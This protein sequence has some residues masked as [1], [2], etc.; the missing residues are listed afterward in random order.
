MCHNSKLYVS[1]DSPHRGANIPIGVQYM[2]DR[3]SGVFV[4]GGQFDANRDKLLR[5]AAKQMLVYHF[6]PDATQ[7]R[8]RWQ[9]WQ[10]SAGSYPTLLRKVALSNGNRQG[11][12]LP[13]A[14]TGMELL[15]SSRVTPWWG[16]NYANSLPGASSRGHDNVVFRYQKAITL[17]G[18]W[19]YTQ[20]AANTPTYD[21][22]PG[23]TRTTTADAEKEGHGFLRSGSDYQTF[24]PA[25]SALDV[26][27]AGSIYNPNLYYDINNNI[28]PNWPNP[29]KYAFEAYY[30]PAGI[31]EPHI[32]ITNGQAYSPHGNPTYTSNNTAWILNELAESAHNLPALLTG[33]YNFGSLYRRLL[34]S[35][36]VGAGG[37]IFLNNANLPN[38]GGVSTANDPKR[39]S[40][41]MYT[42]GCGSRVQ[43]SQG[44]TLT[45]GQ[46]NDPYL[47]TARIGNLSLLDLR[48]GSQ[49]VVNA[50]SVLRIAKGG[51][52]VLRG[53]ASLTL[54]GQL[55]VEAGAY[56][57]VENPADIVTG[58]AGQ[59][60]AS[61]SAYRYA[62][63]A[64]GLGG[65]ACQLYP[66]CQPT[67]YLS[68][69]S[70]GNRQAAGGSLKVN[71]E[72]NL[73]ACDKVYT[74]TAEGDGLN[75]NFSW[76]VNGAPYSPLPGRPEAIRLVI[77]SNNP[78]RQIEVSV[79]NNCNSQLLTESIMLEAEFP[80]CRAT[81][82]VAMYPNPATNTLTF[83][84]ADLRND[85]PATGFA[86]SLYD[87][88]GQLRWQG[89]SRT[90]KLDLNS[91]GLPRGIYG[92]VITQGKTVVRQ[93]L[94]LE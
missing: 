93:N 78:F 30:A 79:G 27:V 51:T 64:L 48:A 45:L 28:N 88:Q 60:T 55:V 26:S 13:G 38:S 68:Y 34:P 4:G 21:Q 19:H 91:T 65:L 74:V 6:S 12:V 31:S 84:Q 33:T 62:N 11:Q 22:A 47:A 73:T 59:L 85:S 18:R 37:Q 16:S 1:I 75:T 42:S 72:S 90:G 10:A 77:H 41:E 25:I 80:N 54:N 46:P 50:G 83:E 53:G 57:C 7:D 9:D 32:N 87:G 43:V 2:I 39:N 61:A 67:L 23:G 63:P 15:R 36:E 76:T 49:A 17:T 52:L 58:P 69:T 29:S 24:I 86:V 40:F 66:P 81:Q 82:S 56:I 94:S 8:A 92:V 35:V 14:F 20:V 89:S 5:P 44:G 71:P 3:L 70:T